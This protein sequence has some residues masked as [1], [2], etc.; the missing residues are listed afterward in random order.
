MSSNEIDIVRFMDPLRMESL[1]EGLKRPIDEIPQF[2]KIFIAEIEKRGRI[3]ELVL[4]LRY[5][6][7]TGGFFSLRKIRED[8]RLG[9]KM[10]FKGKLKLFS[11]KMEGQKEVEKIFK[12]VLSDR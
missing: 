5:K 12:R 7:K 1:K 10:F 8:A 3:Y 11:Q 2:H 6:L 9:L 4:L